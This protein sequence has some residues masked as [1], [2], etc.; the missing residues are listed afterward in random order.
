[1]GAVPP[2]DPSKREVLGR[3]L[4]LG[5]QLIEG[6][7]LWQVQ[8]K[9]AGADA[10]EA[11]QRAMIFVDAEVGQA[12]KAAGRQAEEPAHPSEQHEP[13]C[14][15]DLLDRGK[16]VFITNVKGT[17]FGMSESEEASKRR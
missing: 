4:E 14:I 16:R 10:R 3:L 9:A 8:R 11:I 1:L 6:L 13:L 7:V 12:R 15:Q 5:G 2:L 17:F